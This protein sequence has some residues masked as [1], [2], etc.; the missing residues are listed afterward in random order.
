MWRVIVVTTSLGHGLH[1]SDL[2]FKILR[3]LYSN[4]T[5]DWPVSS[6]LAEKNIE[7]NHFHHFVCVEFSSTIIIQM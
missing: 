5:Y 6:D 3:F 7:L 4:A 2:Y 1:S